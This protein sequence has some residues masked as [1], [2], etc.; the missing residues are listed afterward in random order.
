MRKMDRTLSKQEINTFQQ[1]PLKPPPEKPEIA[2]TPHRWTD[3]RRETEREIE[4]Q[5]DR[6]TERQRGRQAGRQ[7]DRQRIDP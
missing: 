1:T 2:Y 5:R 4:R 3:R 7:T 6:E